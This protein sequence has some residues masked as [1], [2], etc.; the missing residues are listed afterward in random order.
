M[1][2]LL[3]LLLNNSIYYKCSWIRNRTLKP[4]LLAYSSSGLSFPA[5]MLLFPSHRDEPGRHRSPLR[6]FPL[7]LPG[8]QLGAALCCEPLSHTSST[9]PAAFLTPLPLSTSR[10]TD[11]F[12]MCML[13]EKHPKGIK[14]YF[15]LWGVQELMEKRKGGRK[16]VQK[17][18]TT[19]KWT[20]LFLFWPFLF[21]L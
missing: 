21:F 8:N 19:L 1:F 3:S 14:E 7:C 17:R 9:L 10:E 2:T 15:G 12:P 5:Q 11:L 13:C 4:K 16:E 6:R 18:S 20:F